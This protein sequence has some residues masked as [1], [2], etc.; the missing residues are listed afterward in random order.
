VIHSE[1][2]LNTGARPVVSREVQ[3]RVR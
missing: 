1:A 2:R 3:I